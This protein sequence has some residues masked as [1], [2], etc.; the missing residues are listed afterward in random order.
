MKHNIKEQN[1]VCS[2]CSLN[3]LDVDFLVEGEGVYICDK[4]VVKASEIVKENFK[5]TGFSSNSSDKKPVVIKDNLDKHIISQNYAKRIVS[6][7]VYNHLKRIN[8]KYS[9]YSY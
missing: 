3:E 4:C 5:K 8:S 9:E 2:F 7:A 6:V 1:L